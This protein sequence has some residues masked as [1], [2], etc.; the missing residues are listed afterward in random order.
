[1]LTDS[2]PSAACHL[3]RVI[4]SPLDGSCLLHSNDSTWLLSSVTSP[5]VGESLAIRAP[6]ERDF[7]SGL[8]SS[9]PGMMLNPF[10][11]VLQA[12]TVLL[13]ASSWPHYYASQTTHAHRLVAFGCVSSSEGDNF[14]LDGSCL[15]HSNDS[16]WLLS[17]ATSPHVGESPAIRAPAERD[18]TSGLGSSIPDMMLNPFRFVLQAVTVLLGASSWPHYYASQTT[19]AHRLV[20]FGCV[21]SSEGDNF[22]LDGSCLLHSNDSTWLLSS[23]TSPHV[24]E[25]P[26]IRAPAERDFT[27][28][29]GSSIP[30]MMLNPF[31]FVLQAVTVLLGASSWPHYYA[32]QTTHAHRLV[33]FGCASSSEGDNFALDGSCLLHSND[34]TWLLSSVTSP[35]VGESLAIRAPTERDF[36]SGLG[37]SIPDMMLNPFRFVLQAVTVL[38]GASSWPHYYASQTTHAHRLVAFGCVSSSEGDNFALDGSC[39]LHSN[40]STWLLSSVTSPH[41]GESLAIR[42]PTERDFT[43]GLGSSIPGMMLNPFRF[44]L[45]AVTVLLGASSWPHYYASQTTHAHRLVAFGCVSSSEGD[46]FALDGSCLL[47]SNDSTWLLSS[48]TSPHVGESPAIRAPA[49][50]DFTSGLGSNIPGMML[51]PFRFVLQAVTVLLGA[52]SWPHYYASQ[53]THAHRLVAFGCVSSSEGDNFALDGSCLLHSNDSTWLLSSVTSPHVGESLAIRAPTERDFTSGLGSSIPGMMLN[54]FRFVLQR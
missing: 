6:T 17:S 30:D 53:T 19:H 25:S 47:H 23:A 52:S 36:T 51:N 28:G 18:F 1:M 44:V 45:Q 22:A 3:R 35:H 7:T 14:A 41:V 10:R 39:L 32:S 12:V 46:N 42:A 16:T 31:R 48:A 5:H 4:T 26:A 34:S 40:D 43:S 38:L 11:F 50:R 29:L 37:S 20:A 33:A 49:E 54:P 24:G 13:G 21:S 9:I 8:G 15:L 2:W 27:S